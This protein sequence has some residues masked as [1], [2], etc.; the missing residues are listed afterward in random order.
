M[1][2]ARRHQCLFFRSNFCV[3]SSLKQ[4]LMAFQSWV[5]DGTVKVFQI[6]CPG[7]EQPA[8]NPDGRITLLTSPVPQRKACLEAA[9]AEN[10]YP[11]IP[12]Q[13]L[14][15]QTGVYMKYEEEHL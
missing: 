2:N 6:C 3:A 5:A 9:P 14:E 1:L 10:R 13:A 4:S 15:I 12:L 7:F 11:L 8:D